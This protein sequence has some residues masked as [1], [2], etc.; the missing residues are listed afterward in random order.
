MIDDEEVVYS[1]FYYPNNWTCPFCGAFN[2]AHN[3]ECVEC[4]Y[5]WE[6]IQD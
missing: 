6:E 5:G 3:D 2:Q 1:E 4:G